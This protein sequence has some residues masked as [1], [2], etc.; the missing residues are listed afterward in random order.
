[1]PQKVD[2]QPLELALGWGHNESA[3][4]EAFK[5]ETTVGQTLPPA[6]DEDVVLVDEQDVEVPQHG[7][8]YTKPVHRTGTW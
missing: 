5:R 2:G 1:M 7:I 8:H 6:G 3:L 4:V